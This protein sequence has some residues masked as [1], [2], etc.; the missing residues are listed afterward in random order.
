MDSDFYRY[1]QGVTM[2]LVLCLI[3]SVFVTQGC[4]LPITLTGL[5]GARH[6]QQLTSRTR[7][8]C[9]EA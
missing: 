7:L 2:K 6:K 3:F 4:L 8:G 9:V 5:Q 1:S